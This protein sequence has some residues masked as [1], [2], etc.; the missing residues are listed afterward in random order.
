MPAKFPYTASSEQLHKILQ[1]G[2][3]EAGQYCAEAASK[4]PRRRRQHSG[5]HSPCAVTA[6]AK[7]VANLQCRDGTRTVPDTKKGIAQVSDVFGSDGAQ[8]GVSL[9]ASERRHRIS[10]TEAK[11][12]M[13]ESLTYAQCHPE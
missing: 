10:K 11:K 1:K 5:R 13:Q 8:S 6:L 12:V 9:L 3:S 4:V 7:N 2:T